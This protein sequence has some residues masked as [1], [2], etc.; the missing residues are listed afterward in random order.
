[1]I[2]SVF[3]C[4]K[5]ANAQL[6]SYIGDTP[7]KE[8]AFDKYLKKEAYRVITHHTSDEFKA[9]YDEMIYRLQSL[10]SA[11]YYVH[12]MQVPFATKTL[13]IT[14]STDSLKIEDC[15]GPARLHLLR[16]NLFEVVYSPRGGSDDGYD[17]ILLLAIRN[18][19][20]IISMEIESMHD[21]DGPGFFGLN[22]THLFLTGEIPQKYQLT[23]K[24]HD[25]RRYDKKAKN[26]DHYHSCQLKYDYK[27]NLF[28]TS[29]EAINGWVWD[30]DDDDHK[31]QVKG[32]FPVIKFGD[33]AY[34]FINDCWYSVGKDYKSNKTILYN[35]CH[36]PNAKN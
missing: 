25:L 22:E 15:M 16:K 27:L 7:A 4:C 14:T 33:I 5:N 12:I 32:T 34:C 2:V 11:L 20:F 17:N 9:P 3:F 26:F 30:Y 8:K 6:W 35:D 13:T 10:D 1:M 21:Y 29:Y 23:L 18:G 36:R 19:K 28:Y 31:T 24:N